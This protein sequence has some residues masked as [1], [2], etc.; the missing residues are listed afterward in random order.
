M[1]NQVKENKLEIIKKPEDDKPDEI[2]IDDE[3]K[4]VIYIFIYIYSYDIY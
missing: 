1:F 4:R 2:I 3:S